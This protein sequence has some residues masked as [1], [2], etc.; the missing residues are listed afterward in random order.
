[1]LWDPPPP[2]KKIRVFL[3]W[4]VRPGVSRTIWVS[5][6]SVRYNKTDIKDLQAH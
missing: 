1:M 3:R 5:T 2:Y 4:M 6:Y